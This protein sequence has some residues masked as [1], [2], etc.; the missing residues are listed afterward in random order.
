MK[1]FLND[2]LL[3]TYKRG[4]LLLIPTTTHTREE[5]HL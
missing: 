1:H 2:P 4:S 3:S 5:L